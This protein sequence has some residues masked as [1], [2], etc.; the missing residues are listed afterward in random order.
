MSNNKVKYTLMLQ[1]YAQS[2]DLQHT[3]SALRNLISDGV[4]SNFRVKNFGIDLEHP[5]SIEC[6]PSY[7]G[8]VNLIL[9]DDKNP[10][11]LVNSRFSKIE[12]NQFKVINR[13]QTQQSNLYDKDKVDLQTRLIKSSEKIPTVNLYEVT[14][15]GNLKGGTY[16]FYIRLADSDGNKTDFLAESGPISIYKG[17]YDDISSISGTLLDETTDKS[18]RLKI[19]NLDRSF[20]QIYLYFSR[21][22]SDTN[23]IRINKYYQ[24]S[25]AYSINSETEYI[26]VNGFE[27]L[28]EIT[29]DD[30]NTQYN[31]ITGAKTAAQVQNMIFF[32]NITQ[33]TVLTDDLQAISYYIQAEAKQSESIGWIDPK[34]YA[35]DEEN[36]PTLC[37][38]YNPINL[39]YKLGYWPEELYRI[40]IVYIMNDGS[41]T[42]VF[43]LRGCKFSEVDKPNFELDQ[44]VMY[45]DDKL[46]KLDRNAMLNT[47]VYLDNT[48]GVFQLPKATVIDYVAK[49]VKPLYLQ[50]TLGPWVK[51]ELKSRNVKGYFFVRQKRIPSIVCQGYSIGIDAGCSIP[52]IYYNKKYIAES[53]L[54]KSRELVNDY[55]N[56]IIE[57]ESCFGA[58]LLSLDAIVNPDIKSVFDGSKFRIYRTTEDV[59][60][61][62]DSS[63]FRHYYINGGTENPSS[64]QDTGAVKLVYVDSN[65]SSKIVNGYSFS[66][67]IGNAEDI[68]QFGLFKN[69]T[70]YTANNTNLVRGEYTPFIGVVTNNLIPGQI[71]NIMQKDYNS[72]LLI[73]YFIIRG[74]DASP[75]YAI[76]DRYELNDLYKLTS[77]EAYRGD[78]YTNTVT[79]R[80]NRNFVDS[81]V[82][83]NETIID[84]YTWRDNYKGLASMKNGANDLKDGQGDYTNINRSDIN[85]VMLGQWVT[86][87]CMSSFNLGVRA[88]DSSNTQENALLGS[89]RSFYPNYNISKYKVH[90]VPDSEILNQGYNATVGQKLNFI[91][92][93]T[94]YTKDLFD[95]RI[96]FSKVQSANNFENAYRVFQSLAYQDVERQYGA[97]TKLL[98]WG[99]NLLC[100]F[101]HGVG[102]MPVNEKALVSTQ[103]G[104]SI[105]M[106]GADVLQ[107]QITVLNPDFGSTWSDSIIKTPIG[108][109]GIDTTA[110][111]IWRVS[112]QNGFETISDMKVQ[113]FLNENIKLNELDKTVIIGV[114]NVKTHYNNFKGDVMFT[115]YNDNKSVAWNLCFNER[116]GKW[117]TQY[118]W[119]PVCSENVDNIFYSMDREKTIPMVQIYRNKNAEYDLHSS[120]SVWV[121]KY[122]QESE[123]SENKI[124]ADFETNITASDGMFVDEIKDFTIN[125]VVAGYYNGENIVYSTETELGT[126]KNQGV[127][128]YKD[129]FT[130]EQIEETN[131]KISAKWEDS[132]KK[133]F[134]DLFAEKKLPVQ[135]DLYCSY[136][137]NGNTENVVIEMII[138]YNNSD[139]LAD[140]K[141]IKEQVDKVL[142]NGF[143]VHGQAGIFDNSEG[144]KISPSTWYDKKYPFEFEYVCNDQVGMH[145]IFDNLV[146]ISNNVKPSEFEF[147]IDGDVYRD[148]NGKNLKEDIFGSNTEVID[149]PDY[150]NKKS[151]K[152][153]QLCKDVREVGRRK[154]NTQ[155]KED[156]WYTQIVPIQYKEGSSTKETR[157]RDKYIRIRVRY[158]GDE[159]TVITAL[160]TIYTQSYA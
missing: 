74:L 108:V 59:S 16:V 97:I 36:T 155:Y 37:E 105:H 147:I 55:S 132:N 15:G 20:S 31:L 110:K 100:V 64:L 12:N 77:H 5:I 68:S 141:E 35:P 156:S 43:N 85:T 24:V 87:K 115:F 48:Y 28:I 26:S 65:T 21:A 41:L 122:E 9:T 2:G 51:D 130:C 134:K 29:E 153:T 73:N 25:S 17:S 72:N 70:D 99:S 98:P 57:S 40:G 148:I 34:T 106:Y 88:I 8:T 52:M 137:A 81:E 39:Y 139:I 80:I 133:A 95:S 63:Q 159:L 86:F 118:D 38:Y 89:P 54:N 33:N 140:S 10:P 152:I 3:Y 103:S 22:T 19:T 62:Q 144:V 76:T 23:G 30:L 125:K 102:L 67:K 42:P 6:Q 154:G 96:A 45:K 114:R 75:F 158:T 160:K 146:I 124:V 121:P 120:V 13:N 145:K 142:T 135:Y 1:R 104:Q 119:V 91:A 94:P 136:V 11:R 14:S 143:Y 66:T 49:E 92:P 4:I 50:F 18:L 71:Y 112:Q 44:T 157:I 149:S 107:N 78:C 138:D 113:K 93:N 46:I 111:K 126:G 7:D 117:I 84:K 131:W 129:L 109:Y 69:K 150:P 82:P 61:I 90:K 47:P 79:I 53:F 123:S 101:E 27:S 32:G 83:V 127:L 56:H 116:L 151:L 60:L 128:E 58:G